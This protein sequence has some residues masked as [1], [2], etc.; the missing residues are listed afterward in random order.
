VTGD[1]LT[2]VVLLDDE[3]GDKNIL[4]AL[5]KPLIELLLLIG[6]IS[7]ATLPVPAC[8]SFGV[9]GWKV[10]LPDRFV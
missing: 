9:S 6:V 1:R 2:Q 7:Y 10:R 8:Q 5:L 4:A 3:C